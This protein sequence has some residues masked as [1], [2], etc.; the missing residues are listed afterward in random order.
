MA[1]GRAGF[2][3]QLTGEIHVQLWCLTALAG[4]GGYHTI[5][6]NNKHSVKYFA[7]PTCLNS[8]LNSYAYHQSKAKP[9]LTSLLSS[10]QHRHHHYFYYNL[11]TVLLMLSQKL[12]FI[13][14]SS[15]PHH[16]SCCTAKKIKSGLRL[17]SSESHVRTQRPD[18]TE[19]QYLLSLCLIQNNTLRITIIYSY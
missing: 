15:N 7:S 3:S 18:K 4:K 2:S 12:L 17:G 11:I 6:P 10:Q 1:H 14:L 8:C 16:S 9:P 13:D 5:L 19:K